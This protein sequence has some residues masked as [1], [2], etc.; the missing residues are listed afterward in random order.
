TLLWRVVAMTPGGYVEGFRSLAA[1]RGPMTFA[2][3]ASNVQALREAGALPTVERL[4]WFTHGFVQARVVEGELV[5][6][7]LRMGSEPDYF[8]RFAVAEQ[9]EGGWRPIPPRQLHAPRD[10]GAM[11]RATWSRIWND[12]AA[13]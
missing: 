7:D 2:G 5:L 4:E 10:A 13:L 8:F 9:A 6:S 11:W 1:D 3:H 12:P